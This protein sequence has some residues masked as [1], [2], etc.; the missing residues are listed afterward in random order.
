M[1]RGLIE[2]VVSSRC[3]GVN[4]DGHPD[5]LRHRAGAEDGVWRGGDIVKVMR[6]IH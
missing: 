2:R 6:L 5:D 4:N 1:T 3:T